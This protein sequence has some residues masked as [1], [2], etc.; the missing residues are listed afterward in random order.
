MNDQELRTPDNSES[1]FGDFDVDAAKKYVND[2]RKEAAVNDP[3]DTEQY[4]QG[5]RPPCWPSEQEN[6]LILDEHSRNILRLWL[7][8]R[9]RLHNI[10]PIR[11]AELKSASTA[12][13]SHNELAEIIDC[14]GSKIL[15]LLMLPLDTKAEML[16]EERTR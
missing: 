2:L 9:E 11:W 13:I 8:G 6:F 5:R 16:A 4:G 12:K 1:P 7:S 3:I 15:D 10:D 14:Y